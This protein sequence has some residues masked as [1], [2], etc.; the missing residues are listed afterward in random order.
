MKHLNDFCHQSAG[1]VAL[2]IGLSTLSGCSSGDNL[3]DLKSY[4][5]KI[6][7]RPTESLAPLP[8]IKILESYFFEPEGMRN[9]FM[10]VEKEPEVVDVINSR[11]LKPD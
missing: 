6:K 8:E 1:I 5:A 9:P 2:F 3:A 11:G 7:A 10:P 4:V